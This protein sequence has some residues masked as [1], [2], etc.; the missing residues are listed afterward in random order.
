MDNIGQTAMGYI[1]GLAGNTWVT[2]APNMGTTV[3]VS[4]ANVDIG[5]RIT[6]LLIVTAEGD[7]ELWHSSETATATS[8][9]VGSSLIVIRTN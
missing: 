2:T 5:W 6:G 9:E 8:V 4:T 3:G 7:L 1:G